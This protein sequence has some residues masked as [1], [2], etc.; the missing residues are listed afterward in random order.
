MFTVNDLKILSD[1]CLETLLTVSLNILDNPE[2]SKYLS[3]SKT[4]KRYQSTLCDK[5]GRVIPLVL[6]IFNRIGFI[7]G[8]DTFTCFEKNISALTD[9]T[10]S[11][12][13]A[14]AA[15]QAERQTRRPRSAFD[16]EPRR[17]LA[18]ESKRASDQL[19]QIREEQTLKFST[20]RPAASKPVESSCLIS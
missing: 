8:V 18:A 19:A 15:R 10:E 20:A 4:S 6:L 1:D 7:D 16:F 5:T 14:L 3:L 9:L 12:R 11:L 17:D 2:D 13:D